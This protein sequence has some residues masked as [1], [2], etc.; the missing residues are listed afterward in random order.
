L[1]CA[2]ADGYQPYARGLCLHNFWSVRVEVNIAWTWLAEPWIASPGMELLGWN[3][4]QSRWSVLMY[5]HI[6]TL[7]GTSVRLK[8]VIDHGENR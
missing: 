6:I 5:Q 8:G 4:W 7:P 1:R 3:C 2:I